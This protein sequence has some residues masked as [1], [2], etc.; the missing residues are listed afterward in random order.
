MKKV[1]LG[2]LAMFISLNVAT[3]QNVEN[4][5]DIKPVSSKKVTNKGK[6]YA[7][8]GWN[9][10]KYS[11]SDITFKGNDY[12]FVLNNVK[13]TDRQT[14]FSF[15][16]Y[17]NP[18]TLTIPQNNY[19]IG[20]FFHENYNVFVGVDHMKYVMVQDQTVDIDGKI[21]PAH[22]D[23]VGDYNNDPIDLTEDFLTFEHTDGLNYVHV[24]VNRF[25]D[26]SEHIGIETE[27]FR[28]NITEGVGVGMLI[29]KTNAKLM[30]F[31]R[32]DEFHLAGFG[33]SIHAGL[34]LTFFKYFFIQTDLKGGY[35]NMSD[36]RTTEFEAD[37]ASQSFTY[38]QAN[39]LIGGR[40]GF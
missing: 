32:Y 22:T 37:K 40:F 34:N 23:F 29:P 3:A 20:Y 9:I 26:V 33:V 19:G 15:D 10:S 27:N 7:Y 31:D 16:V 1:T 35:I 17:F 2:L 12:D 25:D 14:P 6:F 8:W 24:A 30:G 36:I 5:I 21:G 39:I 11:N 13:A 18:V 28:V 4:E 38:T